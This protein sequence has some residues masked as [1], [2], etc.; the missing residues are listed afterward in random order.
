KPISGY[1]QSRMCHFA[2]YPDCYRYGSECVVIIHA[3][4]WFYM[5]ICPFAVWAFVVFGLWSLIE[6][7]S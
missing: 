3:L 4:N 1:I 7:L 2:A 5:Q 6:V